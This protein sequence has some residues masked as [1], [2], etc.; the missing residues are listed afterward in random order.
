MSTKSIVSVGMIIA[1]VHTATS[2]AQYPDVTQPLIMPE[3]PLSSPPSG[4]SELLE[5]PLP[6]S[7]AP[8]PPPEGEI[9]PAGTITSPWLTGSSLNCCGPVGGHGPIGSELY[10]RTGPSIP[11][12]GNFLDDRTQVGWNVGGGGRTL[13]F[14]PSRSAAWT[15]DFGVDYTYN[16]GRRDPTGFILFGEPVAIRALHRTAVR[17]TM[18]REW[19]LNHP[20]ALGALGGFNTRLGFDVGG[21]LGSSHVDLN[22]I[23]EPGG[24]RRRHDVIGGTILG[25]GLTWERQLNGWN[26]LLGLRSEW[27]YNRIDALPG[28]DGDFHDVNMLL[29]GGI[30]F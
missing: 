19:F 24:Y 5:P 28:T 4:E 6:M 25:L 11:I 7:E 10:L 26:L 14:N 17:L 27:R 15:W 16:N 18:G 3:E 13:L 23:D 22:P 12:G 29:T 21:F 1:L 30:R 8:L 9:L 20:A 2:W